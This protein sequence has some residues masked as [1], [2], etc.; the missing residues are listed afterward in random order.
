VAALNQFLSHGELMQAA[1]ATVRAST[2]ALEAFAQS[3]AM[4][5][6]ADSLKLLGDA[7]VPVVD[8]RLCQTAEEAA[9]ALAQ[10]GGAV[11]VKGCSADVVHKSELGLVRLGLTDAVEVRAAFEQIRR[12]LARQGARFDGVIVAKMVSGRREM[13]IGA[14]VDA[15]FGPIVLVGDGGKYV[16]ALP[17]VQLL[18]PPFTATEVRQALERL[19]IAPLLA[20]VR[21]EA[22]L[23]IDRFCDAVLSVGRLVMNPR[24]GVSNLDLNPVLLGAKGEGCVALDAVV[25]VAK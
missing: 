4:L 22:A 17:D 2:R 12:A 25:Y 20:G 13:M 5:N 9:T 15:V 18:I 1:K 23:D 6:E 10:L 21:G 8:Y 11:A 24:A 19:R 7:G 16:E 3:G 14:R